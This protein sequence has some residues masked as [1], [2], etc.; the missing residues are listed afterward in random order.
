M[1]KDSGTRL[2]TIRYYTASD[3]VFYTVDNRPLTDLFTRTTDLN[4][5]LAPARGLRARQTTTPSTS[6]EIEESIWT[7]GTT[8][9]E[10]PLTTITPTPAAAG[11]I[12]INLLSLSLL[13]GTVT[14]TVGTEGLI[15][16]GWAAL[17]RPSLP[18]DY[19]I[20]IAYVYVDEVPTSFSDTIA[21]NNAGHIQDIRVGTGA[22][23]SSLDS[24]Y[25]AGY[26]V[27]I[28]S[29]PV[30]LT[31]SS[32]GG[33]CLSISNTGTGSSHSIS[34]ANSST[35]SA[36]SISQTAD[37]SA[38]S[39]SKT[40]GSTDCISITNGGTGHGLSITQSA[41]GIGISLDKNLGSLPAVSV[42]NKGSGAALLLTCH[43]TGTGVCCEV[44]NVTGSNG[45]LVTQGVGAT[46]AGIRVDG[47]AS[48]ECLIIAQS[49]SSDAAYISQAT[50]NN[51]LVLE[52]STGNTDALLYLDNYT[53]AP[54][55]TLSGVVNILHG[56][57]S[58]EGARAAPA[59]SLYLRTDGGTST[60]L[61]VKTS[62][63]GTTGWTGK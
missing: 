8:I 48:Y 27:T 54:D 21:I 35:G 44:S 13:T 10:F 24:A 60:S 33:N 62:G 34:I 42:L 31:K 51:V 52:K 61:Y 56:A 32:G 39:L 19:H 14:E 23:L 15:A 57:G 50:D 1:S 41:D 3:P 58:P 40:T 2:E 11:K 47:S 36:I 30:T 29:N 4:S 25:R 53:T 46:A 16:A 7:R 12:R 49:G 37:A 38:I 45:I 55:I 59:G 9:G 17:V 6:I 26:S 43:T 18:Y 20:P 22:T 5:Y 63:S 28:G